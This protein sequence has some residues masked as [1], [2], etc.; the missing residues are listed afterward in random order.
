M[1]KPTKAMR[2]GGRSRISLGAAS[3]LVSQ[4]STH[5][6]PTM[7]TRPATAFLDRCLRACGLALLLGGWLFACVF[8]ANVT[9]DFTKA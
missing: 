8:H 1:D 3:G 9:G 7:K 6:K 4:P 5:G 2:P